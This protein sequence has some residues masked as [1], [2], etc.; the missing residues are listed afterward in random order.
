[1]YLVDLRVAIR[2]NS[3]A[4]VKRVGEICKRNLITLLYREKMRDNQNIF[5]CPPPSF[6][7]NY[8]TDLL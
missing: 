8:A 3:D 5:F 4:I 6:F 2:K 7:L 1:M